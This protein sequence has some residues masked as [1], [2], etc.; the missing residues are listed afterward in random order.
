MKARLAG[1]ALLA[2]LALPARV[3]AEPSTSLVVLISEQ[4]GDAV[5]ERL[6]RDLRSQGLSV[7]VLSRLRNP[8][9][10]PQPAGV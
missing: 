8:V 3:R 10:G 7:L 4:P 5:S 9:A 6:E 2:C 1:A